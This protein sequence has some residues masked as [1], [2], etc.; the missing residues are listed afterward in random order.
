LLL[1]TADLII[2]IKDG[3]VQEEG[4]HEELMKLEGLY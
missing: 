1:R 2:A 4:T 3:K